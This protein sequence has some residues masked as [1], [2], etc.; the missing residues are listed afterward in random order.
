MNTLSDLTIIGGGAAGLAAS[1]CASSEGLRT[2]LVE[3]NKIGGQAGT[4]FRIENYMGFP[5]GL[6]GQELT[7]KSLK[8]ARRFG[9]NIIYP[10]EVV[11]I[12][13][14][15]PH[16]CVTFD[17]GSMI[18]SHAIIIATGASYSR[19]DLKK[20]DK[21][22]GKGIFYG[23]SKAEMELCQNREIFIVGG[24]NSAGQA[25]VFFSRCASQ[26]N[27]VI[28]GEGLSAT[29]SHYLSKR[30]R[31]IKNINVMTNSVIAELKG[32]E[33]LDGIVIENTKTGEQQL[34]LTPAVFIF[35]GAKP[36]SKWLNGAVMEDDYGFIKTGS[37]LYNKGNLIPEWTEK[38]SPFMFETSI[39]GVFAV[40]DV[41][42]GSIKRV[43]SAV[44]EGSMAIS[45][46]HQ[47]IE[48]VQP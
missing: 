22:L 38:R 41:R 32:R 28:R 48:E 10:S 47:Y 35:I 11:S 1:I 14:E 40:G 7:E 12:Q 4:S 18:K 19:L 25:A 42:S 23:A 21:F 39:P 30:I 16:K 37:D 27:M 2:F 3:K 26:V 17:D 24:A 13:N 6:S 20:I 15:G 31:D 43:A 45:V 44:G 33:H 34:Y 29:M 36:H 8:Q 5:L 46:I 9:A